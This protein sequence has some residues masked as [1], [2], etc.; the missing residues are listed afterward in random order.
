MTAP[1]Q[2]TNEQQTPNVDQRSGWMLLTLILSRADENMD[3]WENGQ[4]VGHLEGT[5]EEWLQ[6]IEA[7]RQ[8]EQ[9]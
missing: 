8:A 3:V 9:L 2:T 1:I 6:R 4:L 7:L 5:Y